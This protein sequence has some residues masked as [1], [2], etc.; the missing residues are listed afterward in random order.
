MMKFSF[1]SAFPPAAEHPTPETSNSTELHIT[2]G[3]Q[4]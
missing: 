3:A 2:R 4:L 1:P